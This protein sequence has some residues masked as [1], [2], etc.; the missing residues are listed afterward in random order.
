MLLTVD[1]GNTNVT[2]GLFHGDD[3]I[4]FGRLASHVRRTADEYAIL[5]RQLLEMNGIERGRIQ[6]I[7]LGSVVPALTTVMDDAMLRAVGMRAFIVTHAVRLPVRNL[8]AKPGEVGVDRLANAAGGIARYGAPLLVVDLGTAVTIDVISRDHEYLGGAILPGIEMSAEALSRRTA[9]LPLA[10]PRCPDQAIGRTSVESIRSGIM[11]G[12][13]GA[14]DHL[15]DLTWDQ[16]GYRTDVVAT[17]GH[18]S[19]ILAESRHI[20]HEDAEITLF[21][22]T[23]IWHI[24]HPADAAPPPARTDADAAP[25]AGTRKPATDRARATTRA[26][27]STRARKT[28]RSAAAGEPPA[29]AKRKPAPAPAPPPRKRTPRRKKE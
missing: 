4:F 7:V 20:R 14:I 22:L 21:G 11:H 27:K 12:L 19:T 26:R 8:Y 24:N 18:S 6:A 1:I 25:Q 13:V 29:A 3:C 17:G 28:T 10:A 23:R 5:T 15:I 16:L 9:R 2:V